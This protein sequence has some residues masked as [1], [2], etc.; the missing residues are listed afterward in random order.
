MLA[1]SSLSQDLEQF[2]KI[3]KNT[4]KVSGGMNFSTTG[5]L[6]DNQNSTRDPYAWYASGN[7]SFSA[8]G[9]AF[10]FSYSISNQNK[11]FS[12][13]SNITSLNP[14][15]KWFKSH[16]GRTSMSF[17]PYTLAG[18]NFSGVGIEL[19]PK[20]FGFQAMYGMLSKAVEYDPTKNDINIISYERWA[21]SVMFT[22]KIKNTDFKIISLKA[23]DKA[24]SLM[25]PPGLSSVKPKDNLVT[26]FGVKTKVFKM[27]DLDAEFASS[28]LTN[29]VRNTDPIADKRWFTNFYPLINGNG[30]SSNYN[31]YKGSLSYSLKT[32]KLGVA[33]EH[34]DPNYQTL[35]GLFFTNDL[36]NLTFTPSIS[37]LKN[38]VTLALNTGVQRNNINKDKASQTERWV[39]S[40]NLNLQVFKGFNTSFSYS[41]FSSFTRNNP[42]KDPFTNQIMIADTC[43]VYQI[44]ENF[45]TNVSYAFGKKNKTSLSTS[46]TYQE[47]SNVTGKLNNASAF[48]IHANGPSNPFNCYVNT[49]SYSYSIAD[50]KISIS[51]NANSNL[52][53]SVLTNSWFCGP[54][55]S[56]SKNFGKDKPSL[57]AGMTYN[58]NYQNKE[59]TN[60]VFN[61]RLS[62]SHAPKIIAE[63]YGKLNFSVSSMFLNKL[64][65]DKVKN[66]LHELTIIANIAYNF[67]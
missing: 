42:L 13:P 22:Y 25:N 14:S 17:S 32:L 52:S 23:Y 45:V 18:V 40:A 66:K 54:T 34:I 20:K 21:Y 26:S 55:F 47:T 53:K 67:K 57:S 65:T 8:F 63:K 4:V 61:Y 30:T 43:N 9:F 46:F 49:L 2:K 6:T 10:P 19:T 58:R 24:N 38:K 3:D 16:I 64:P 60:N 31:A 12:Q 50:R 35:G 48:G 27:F 33:Y 36:E 44:S 41:N 15:Y 29:N 59:L 56:L 51:V 11:S 28:M 1:I 7:I 5:F 37:F 62:V 39:G